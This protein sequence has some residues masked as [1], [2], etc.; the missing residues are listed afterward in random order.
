MPLP[1][2][3]ETLGSARGIVAA[4]GN[5][6]LWADELNAENKAAQ[7]QQQAANLAFRQQQE[8]QRQIERE[9]SMQQREQAAAA[10]QAEAQR[11]QDLRAGVAKAEFTK[12]TIGP[13]MTDAQRTKAESEVAKAMKSVRGV[14]AGTLTDA[15]AKDPNANKTTGGFLGFGAKP[16]PE[17]Q[18]VAERALRAADPT[19]LNDDD[20]AQA[21]ALNPAPFDELDK[22]RAAL[23]ADAERRN[24][25]QAATQ[26]LARAKA[27]AAGVP[28]DELPT[29][30][31]DNQQQAQGNIYNVAAQAGVLDRDAADLS[32]HEARL[33]RMGSDLENLRAKKAELQ[34]TLQA[35]VVGPQSAQLH[36]QWKAMH[37]DEQARTSMLRDEE[38]SLRDK[39]RAFEAKKAMHE[40][41]VAGLGA[42]ARFTDDLPPTI[43]PEAA[44]QAAKP[45]T[46]A[47]GAVVA[48]ETSQPDSLEALAKS[49]SKAFWLDPS[50]SSAPT[51][52]VR[53][54]STKAANDSVSVLTKFNEERAAAHR[55]IM[56]GLAA[57]VRSG[58]ISPDEAQAEQD[59]AVTAY[60][61]AHEADAFAAGQKLDNALR[62]FQEGRIDSDTLN[63]VFHAAGS[64]KSGVE[65]FKDRL[66]D[67]R[68]RQ[69]ATDKLTKLIIGDGS[70][71]DDPGL[72]GQSLALAN[73]IAQL[74]EGGSYGLAKEKQ[75]ELAQLRSAHADKLRGELVKMGID[76]GEHDAIIANAELQATSKV[77]PGVAANVAAKGGVG[78]WAAEKLPFVGGVIEAARLLPYA[79]TASKLER[80]ETPSK[81]ELDQLNEFVRFSNQNPTFAA[82]TVE[83][84]TSLPGFAIELA[85]TEGIANAVKL[86]G[87]KGLTVALKKMATS[88]GRELMSVALRKLAEKQ[89][90]TNLGKRFASGLAQ[91]AVRLPFASAGRVA[92]KYMHDA[93]TQGVTLTPDETNLVATIDRTTPNARRGNVAR[94]ADAVADTFIENLSE[95]SGRWLGYAMPKAA[96]EALTKMAAPVKERLFKTALVR[97]LVS[98]NPGVPVSTLSRVLAKA[99]IGSPLSE[100]GEERVGDLARDL[101]KGVSTGQWGI[102]VPTTEQLASEFVTFLVPGAVSALDVTR[103]FGKLDSQLQASDAQGTQHI[104]LLSNPTDAAAHLSKSLGTTIAPDEVKSARDLIGNVAGVDSVRDIDRA[105]ESLMQKSNAAMQSGDLDRASKFRLMALEQ[106]RTR[107]RAA[108]MDMLKAVSA[109]RQIADI[110]KQADTVQQHAAALAGDMSEARQAGEPINQNAL[111]EQ[112][113]ALQYAQALRTQADRASALIKIARGRDNMLTAQEQ[114]ALGDA[115]EYGPQGSIITDAARDELRQLAPAAADYIR[116]SETQRREEL[117]AATAQ[118]TPQQ[119][120]A[121]AVT[122]NAA[123]VATDTATGPTEGAAGG[124]SPSAAPA[125]AETPAQELKPGVN[126]GKGE[127]FNADQWKANALAQIARNTDKPEARQHMVATIGAAHEV[128]RSYG[129]IFEGGV[130]FAKSGVPGG[131]VFD[132]DRKALTIN[133]ASLATNTR[134]LQGDEL[135]DFLDDRLNHEVIHVAADAVLSQ[136]Q[137]TD[138]WKRLGKHDAGKRLMRE[139][140]RAYFAAYEARNEKPPAWTNYQAGHE[141]LRMMVQDK[142]FAHRISEAVAVD[143]G[144]LAD[145]RDFLLKIADWLNMRIAALPASDRTTLESHRD[146]VIEA[147]RALGVLPANAETDQGGKS[148]M[149]SGASSRNTDLFPDKT[150]FMGK[151]S[152]EAVLSNYQE[153]DGFGVAEYVNPDTGTTDVYLAAFGDNDFIAYIRVYDENGKPTNRFTSKLER[154]S[155]A[156]GVTK[157]M[158]SDLQSRLP[159]GHEYTEDVSVS[160]DGLKFIA[161]QLRQGYEVALDESGKPLTQDVAVS[162]ESIVNDLP[163]AVDPNGKFE[164]IRI[165]NRAEFDKV[166][167]VLGKML[168]SFG[169]GLGA[170]NVRWENGTAFIDIPVLRKKSSTTATPAAETLGVTPPPAPAETPAGT[171]ETPKTQE[172]PTVAATQAD[173]KPAKTKDYSRYSAEQLALLRES[174]EQHA[175]EVAHAKSLKDDPETQEKKLKAAGMR[176]AARFRQITGKLTAKEQAAKAAYE[177]SNHVGKAVSVDGV[178]GEIVGHAFGRVKVKLASGE[179][180]SV[181]AEK[182]GEPIKSNAAEGDQA[183]GGVVSTSSTSAE[184]PASSSFGA[185]ADAADNINQP[186]ATSNEIG[187]GR[188]NTPGEEVV[189]QAPEDEAIATPPAPKATKPKAERRKKIMQAINPPDEVRNDSGVSDETLDKV[190]KAFE[191]LGATERAGQAGQSGNGSDMADE[192]QV[193]QNNS[194]SSGGLNEAEVLYSELSGK[195]GSNYT[196][197][198]DSK[199][200]WWHVRVADHDTR[201]SNEDTKDIAA[202]KRELIAKKHGITQEYPLE[203][204]AITDSPVSN[205]R[206]KAI[207]QAVVQVGFSETEVGQSIEDEDF[208]L[209][210]FTNYGLR[211]LDLRV[212]KMRQFI[213][214]GKAQPSLRTPDIHELRRVETS[215]PRAELILKTADAI[216]AQKSQSTPQG[217]ASMSDRGSAKTGIEITPPSTPAVNSFDTS[218]P[219]LGAPVRASVQ[220]TGLPRDRRAAFMDLADSLIEQGITEPAKLAK[221]LEAAHPDGRLRKFSQAMWNYLGTVS[222]EL[223]GTHDWSAIYATKK[224]EQAPEPEFSP[225]L[226]QWVEDADGYVGRVTAIDANDVVTL[227]MEDGEGQTAALPVKP[228]SAPADDTKP[229]QSITGYNAETPAE[230]PVPETGEASIP[231]EGFG[232]VYQMSRNGELKWMVQQSDKR[233][234]GD[235]IHDT[236]REAIEESVRE[237]KRRADRAQTLRELEAKQAAEAKAKAEREDLGSFTDGM[238]PLQKGSVTKQLSTRLLYK[239]QET[240]RRDLIQRLVT[241]GR[242][243]ET[244]DGQRV[245][246][247]DTGAFLGEKVLTKAG[248]DYAL[249]LIAQRE[250]SPVTSGGI[251]GYSWDSIKSAQQGGRL[252]ATLKGSATKPKATSADY[253][254]LEKN[255]AEWLYDNGM[256]GVI[257][258]LGLPMEKPSTSPVDQAAHEA[259]TSPL[260]DRPEPTQ[261]QKEAGNYKL[262]HLNISGLDISVENPAGSERKGTDKDG[263][264]WSVKMADHYG[265]VKST[266]GRDGDNIDI[267]VEPGTP[268]DF[269]GPVFVVNQNAQDGSFD[270]HKAIIGPSVKSAA[271]AKKLYLRNYSPG[272]KG[273]GDIVRFDSPQAFKAWATERQRRGAVRQETADKFAVNETPAGEQQTA[274]PSTDAPQASEIDR[275][276]ADAEASGVVLSDADK[277]KIRKA[278]EDAEDAQKQANRLS[279]SSSDPLNKGT[280]FPMGVGF[281]RMT[282]R[283]EQRIDASVKKAGEAVRFFNKAK[284]LRAD[285]EALLAGKGTE[286]DKAAKADKRKSYQTEVAAKLLTWKKGDKIASFTIERVNMDRDGYPSSYTISGDGIVKG[287]HD[288]V[289]VVKEIFGGDKQAFR[290]TIDEA[291]TAQ[292]ATKDGAIVTMDA[293]QASQTET[294]ERGDTVI[295]TDGAGKQAISMIDKLDTIDGKPVA[296]VE[297]FGVRTVP[298][299]DV[300]LKTKSSQRLNRERREAEA[301]AK[302]GIPAKE[303]TTPEPVKESQPVKGPALTAQKKFLLEKIDDAIAEAPAESRFSAKTQGLQLTLSEVEQTEEDSEAWKRLMTKLKASYAM[304]SKLT[305]Y[306]LVRDL[307]AMLQESRRADGMV[308]IEIPGDGTFTI[309]NSKKALNEF[310]QI[311]KSFP[312][313]VPKPDLPTA[314][315]LKASGIPA[316]AKGKVPPQDKVRVVGMFASKD[317]TRPSINFVADTGDAV[318]ATDGRVLFFIE[319]PGEGSQEKPVFYKPTGGKTESEDRYPQWRQVVPK[320]ARRVFSDIDTG[321]L[322]QIAK[323]ASAVY[324][325]A[326]RNVKPNNTVTI[327]SPTPRIEFWK[328]AD[329]SLGLATPSYTASEINGS[330]EHNV[331]PGAESIGVLDADY[332]MEVLRAM[333]ALGS[334]SVNIGIAGTQ[335][336]RNTFT[337]DAGDAHAVVMEMAAPVDAPAQAETKPAD[338][339][340][341]TGTNTR[342]VTITKP[343][344]LSA[345]ERPVAV[346]ADQDAAYMRAVESGDMATA[347]RMVDEAA[348]AAGYDVGPLWHGTRNPS[349]PVIFDTRRQGQLTGNDIPGTYFTD[350]RTYSANAAGERFGNGSVNRYF[351]KLDKMANAEH[352]TNARYLADDQTTKVDRKTEH[353]GDDGKKYL[354]HSRSG[355]EVRARL[356]KQGFNGVHRPT[357]TADEWIAFEPNQIKSADPITRDEQG[358]VIPLSQRFNSDSN[359]ILYATERPGLYADPEFAAAMEE[360]TTPGESP[361]IPLSDAARDLVRDTA[362]AKYGPDFTA[363]EAAQI[364]MNLNGGITSAYQDQRERE[365]H[366]GWIATA[367]KILETDGLDNVARELLA[368]P[369]RL[370]FNPVKVKLAQMAAD[371]L[372]QRALL[373]RS[374]AD[375]ETAERLLWAYNVT[376]TQA[377][378]AVAARDHVHA[379]TEELHRRAI[380][381]MLFTP[382]AHKRAAIERAISLK[383]KNQRIAELERQ[384][385]DVRTKAAENERGILSRSGELV[386]DARDEAAKARAAANAQVAALNKQIAELRAQRDQSQLLAEANQ[387]RIAAIEADLARDFGL[388]LHDL[389]VSREALVRLRGSAIVKNALAGFNQK[390]AL[391][392][393]LRMEGKSDR[394]IQKQT[395]ISEKALADVFARVDE[396]LTKQLEPWLDRGF[397]LGDFE[398]LDD[399]GNRIDPAKIIDDKGNLLGAT[400]RAKITTEEKAARLKSIL[401]A[402]NSTTEAR[403]TGALK[404]TARFGDGNN[405]FGFDLN[406]PE[407]AA[408][409]ARAIQRTDSNAS[410]MIY[411]Y[412]I[413]G[414]LSGPATQTAN[415]AGN[416]ASMALEFAIQRPLEAMINATLFRD[417][418][419]AQLGEFRSMAKYS[420]MIFATAVNR[421]KRAWQTEISTFDAERLDQPLVIRGGGS[422]LE[423]EQFVIG[424]TPGRVIRTPSRLL[425]FADEFAKY[426]IAGLEAAAQAHRLAKAN[427]LTGEEFDKFVASQVNTNGS[428]AWLAAVDKAH[429]LTFTSELPDMLKKANDMLRDRATTPG[430]AA[431]KFFLRMVFPFVRTPY[432]IFATGLRK[433]PLGTLRMAGKATAGLVDSWKGTRPFFDSYPKAALAGDMAEQL[434]GWVAALVLAGMAEGDPDDERKHILI[435]GTRSGNDSRGEAQLLNRTRGGETTILV[436]GKPVFNYGRIEPFATVI[437]TLVDAMRE[438]KKV[439][440]GEPPAKAIENATRAL[441]DQ[442][443]SKT[444]LQGF[445]GLMQLIDGRTRSLP[446]AAVKAIVTG[447]VPNLVRQPL[448]NVDGFARDTRNAPWYYQAL[449][450]ASLA[451]PLYDLY[452]RPIEKDFSPLSRIALGSATTK[453]LPVQPAD[454]ALERWNKT[455]EGDPQQQYNPV[456]PSVFRFKDAQGKWQQMRPDVIARFR[457]DAGRAFAADAIAQFA[458]P[459]APTAEEV[460]GLRSVKDRSYD[461]TKKNLLGAGVQPPQVARPMPTL[462]ELFGQRLR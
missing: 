201:T 57:R 458:S 422:K 401:G 270:E 77:R 40:E 202:V 402:I 49:G 13:L 99:N 360:L 133:L 326:V 427:G 108:D 93:A 218:A 138:I 345:T 226:G 341:Q 442:A 170:Q 346:S 18:A 211:G 304:T 15:T 241:E 160:T 321:R 187:Q 395:G 168:E 328:N 116:Q 310:K 175:K 236:K 73:E 14:A 74:K 42:P 371:Q 351:L 342:L 115:V 324:K 163:I 38:Q 90:A 392:Q 198:K 196:Y 155:K 166:R 52:D 264:A 454:R 447:A 289:D 359:S 106:S 162:G 210:Q 443:R 258:R 86:G 158:L 348:K 82:Q 37:A 197:L 100:M 221:V 59:K 44:K 240:S 376:G 413:N 277:A 440:G 306:D 336:G 459:T 273:A 361:F 390:E 145:L 113:V 384:L 87:M 63:T 254:L 446:D 67:L 396:A 418:A 333:R 428:Q 56:N 112:Q 81:E 19:L 30:G 313:T 176:H 12:S 177:A 391:A 426:L 352:E 3:S 275:R 157:K 449:P 28:E 441:A 191:G 25:H 307:R 215:L 260:N 382:P 408:M 180:K 251:F 141:L 343:N 453:V 302:A 330:Y 203:V 448:R 26:Q 35:G 54:A 65:A 379:S 353:R 400:L 139:V 123:A 291:R 142:A 339:F 134:G 179:V 192:N 23:D 462:A 436:N 263:K 200:R 172:K 252:V 225:S 297:W 185:V 435:T 425:N 415:I 309:L 389:F 125:P 387:A 434:V 358:N 323:Q 350:S 394:Q 9:Q 380:T 111:Q 397:S 315:T 423:S 131:L 450:L 173:K 266:T 322:W 33:Q 32:N 117:A 151:L 262:G 421:A 374:P 362:G 455:H 51:P 11:R 405:G 75:T 169:V 122:G 194:S 43:A 231:S 195:N 250:A 222:P 224:A 64:T 284:L 431:L 383:E 385:E 279:G 95:R 377:G 107:P 404:R 295:W 21:R 199:N 137:V 126:H 4:G 89:G 265:Y 325:E 320:D 208:S 430:G 174:D 120:D 281:T 78:A 363:E 223:S 370:S 367:A 292:Q 102:T 129:K 60:E 365:T 420:S 217:L 340:R 411:E 368:D 84:L 167:P 334:D 238:T 118:T 6:S 27:I 393:R 135:R 80:G 311:A 143:K 332:V 414:L 357:A 246:S 280:A 355:V 206:A 17:A 243:V 127:Q 190:R 149:V 69:D 235:S 183:Q 207:S 406:R 316:L 290:K 70:A 460:R 369:A 300:T 381:N 338:A 242:K 268:E 424:G 444:F 91:E 7:Q 269:S 2:L 128:L 276:I 354:L 103:R 399:Q 50:R 66:G 296:W 445:D 249:H 228:T 94:I 213:E 47:Q 272:W 132:P 159:A 274:L 101:W 372:A 331:T 437:S 29:F 71:S 388:T 308:T 8:Q 451:E 121:G 247:D 299:A 278:F 312:T 88:E 24:K 186:E 136:E 438:W 146:N 110:R 267:F 261:A 283:A 104:A 327:T 130:E 31:A 227:E 119:G 232:S 97:S 298:L 412:W 156:P 184:A 152:Q 337:F 154:R 55:D 150:D 83:G 219:A 285:V 317:E 72:N 58:E 48:H 419:G 36:S 253:D 109:V 209:P 433:T 114:R 1:T 41:Q 286:A 230:M 282:K 335:T 92:G 153:Q 318:V 457:R 212:E 305:K 410:D 303:I 53:K 439:K 79:E 416:T 329:G 378:R 288:K 349:Q 147:L 239:G 45:V 205:E 287:V 456:H 407:H 257:D 161:G 193:A 164:N 229:S 347:Q 366:A 189:Y 96:R 244:E 344:E 417:A 76:A 105:V 364:A 314:T 386:A 188:D 34:Q 124:G 61:K 234:F 220:Q 452:G 39:R 293:P 204:N 398:Q 271:Q 319:Q 62:D 182:I 20:L 373:Q 165:T 85:S 256:F 46:D 237:T 5:A 171:S 10:K 144:L 429:R 181:D 216:Q 140:E 301:A 432:N 255:G 16:T 248:I 148:V 409:V 294:P 214:W 233:G 68:K 178:N 356:E 98:A 245:L 461:A 22:K 375:R 403:N 259:A